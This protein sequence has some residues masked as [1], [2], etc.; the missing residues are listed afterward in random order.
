MENLMDNSNSDKFKCERRIFG[1]RVTTLKNKIGT[2][3]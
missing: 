3:V 1:G 2:E